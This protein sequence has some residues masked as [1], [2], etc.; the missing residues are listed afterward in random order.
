MVFGLEREKKIIGIFTGLLQ[1]FPKNRAILVQ[2][3]GEEK[4]KKRLYNLFMRRE[5]KKKYNYLLLTLR[6]C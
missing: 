3:L 5:I 1:Y 2:K 4:I 6:T